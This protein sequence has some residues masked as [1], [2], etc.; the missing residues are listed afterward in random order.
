M[1]REAEIKHARIA[2]LAAVGW[3]ASELCH[4]TFAKMFGT[5]IHT[6]ID[7]YIL[8]YIHTYAHTYIHIYIYIDIHVNIQYVHTYIHTYM[9][10]CIH[11]YIYI[12]IH[13]YIQHIFSIF[14]YIC[15]DIMIYH[16]NNFP[17]F[18][19]YLIDKNPS[20]FN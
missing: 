16:F 5:Y 17:L 2:M 7:T 19:C 13:T 9:H 15:L 18:H 11:T 4:Y 14:K 1:L 10:T 20:L 12:D 6:H 8:I 3:P